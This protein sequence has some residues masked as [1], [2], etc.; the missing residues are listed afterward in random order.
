MFN[1][2]PTKQ[3]QKSVPQKE[4]EPTVSAARRVEDIE[5]RPSEPQPEVSIHNIDQLKEPTKEQQAAFVANLDNWRN[6]G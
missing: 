4:V 1:F 5:E 3:L 6:A 2:N